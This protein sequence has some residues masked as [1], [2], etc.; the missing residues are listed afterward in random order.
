MGEVRA[1]SVLRSAALAGAANALSLLVAA[2][3]LDAF[4]ITAGW[5]VF[6]V[7][8]VTVLTLL[9]RGIVLALVSRFIRT[10]TIVGGLVLTYVALVITDG[11]TPE[12]GFSL[13]GWGTWLGVTVMVWSAGIAYGEVDQHAP[14]EVPPVRR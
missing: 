2:A 13:H 14:P 8:L 12:G 9:L 10:Y 11:V 7:V 3:V 4:V 6:A 5:F 1:S